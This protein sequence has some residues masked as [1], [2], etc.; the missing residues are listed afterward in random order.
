MQ[1]VATRRL[2]VRTDLERAIERGELT[3]LYQPVVDIAS[4]RPVGVEALVRWNHPRWGTVFPTEFIAV[5][6]ET[7]LISELG[8]H[9]L[10]EACR[11]C[12]EWHNELMDEPAFSVSVNVSPRQ[13]REPRF[14]S[15]VWQVLTETG[16]NPSRLI[17][18]VTETFMLDSPENAGQRLREIK[19][20]GVR[21]A[22]DD[23]GTGYS[24]LAMLRTCRSTFSRSTRHS[25]T[26][27]LTTRGAPRSPR[28]SSG[29][30]G[31]L[32][33]R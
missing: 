25:S 16:L 1:E 15:D 13:L 2:E 24:S 3:L 30:A 27:S 10:R 5:A 29:S 20:L 23:C 14:V 6:E 8:L 7:G 12:Q 31:P 28:R 11:Q 26:T 33:C 22:L 18:E 17:L 9:L 32:A 21:I 19:A 4:S